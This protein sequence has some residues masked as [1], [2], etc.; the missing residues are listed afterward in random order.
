M[1]DHGGENVH[2]LTEALRQACRCQD[3]ETNPPTSWCDGPDSPSIPHHCDCPLYVIELPSPKSAP[4]ARMNAQAKRR[5]LL[6]DLF[7]RTVTDD[8][9]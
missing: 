2:L 4:N 6:G 9:R 1:G 3:P 7:G 5:L 8:A